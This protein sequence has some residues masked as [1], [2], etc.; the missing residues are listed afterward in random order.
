[1]VTADT[2][3]SATSL[4]AQSRIMLFL[5]FGDSRVRVFF[6]VSVLFMALILNGDS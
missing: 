1:M 6:A 5:A 4:A 2:P 3:S